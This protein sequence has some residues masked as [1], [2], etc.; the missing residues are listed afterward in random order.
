[1]GRPDQVDDGVVRP[2]SGGNR[3]SIESIADHR[4]RSLRYARQ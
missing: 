4:F 2:K 1:M 3:I